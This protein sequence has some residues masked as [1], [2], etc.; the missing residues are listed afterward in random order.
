MKNLFVGVL[1]ALVLAAAGQT[2]AVAQKLKAEEF[3]AKHL[4][5]L[6]TAEARAAVKNRMAVGSVMVKFISQKNQTAEGRAVLVSA[7]ARN[8]I[9]MNLNAS[10]YASEKFTFDGKKT[11]VGFAYNGVRS[12]LGAFILSN[13]WIVDESLLGGALAT[14][15][16]LGDPTPKGKISYNGI[17]KDD[18]KEYHVVGYSKKGGGDVEVK[19]FFNKD[20]FRHVR[21]EYVRMSSAGIGTNPNQSSG[22]NETRFKLTEEFS[23]FKEEKGIML[24]HAYRIH[25]LTSGQRG[26]TEIEW[27]I[28]L[29]DFVFNQNLDDS[30]FAAGQ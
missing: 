18:G 2:A 5:S 20:T 12:A 29:A 13:S 26:T 21:T 7:D 17:K 22:F 25:Y 4:E 15:W 14:S 1:V 28:S 8:F 3:L 9:G 11:A 23:D 30:T 19:L 6:G 27:N 24:P 16:A 10:D